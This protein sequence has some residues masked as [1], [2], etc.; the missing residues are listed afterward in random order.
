MGVVSSCRARCVDDRGQRDIDDLLNTGLI[1]DAAP[2]RSE[3]DPVATD[4][5]EW[6]WL[7]EGHSTLCI[8]EL[9]M[10]HEE[11]IQRLRAA[12]NKQP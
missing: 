6:E 3:R 9:L 4:Y 7:V 8:D 1:Y 2:A 5:G 11:A 10:E 12:V